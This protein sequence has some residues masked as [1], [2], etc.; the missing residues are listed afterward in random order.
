MEE[1]KITQKLVDNIFSCL[2]GDGFISYQEDDCRV[3]QKTLQDRFGVFLSM[4]ECQQ[5]WKWRSDLW[6][7]S[8]LSLGNFDEGSAEEVVDYFGQWLEEQDLWEQA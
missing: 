8:F 2:S 3:I 1:R 4:N 5:F 7:A 6:D